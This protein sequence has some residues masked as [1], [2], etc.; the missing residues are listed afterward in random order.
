MSARTNILA[1][2]LFNSVN[3]TTAFIVALYRAD[4][5]VFILICYFSHHIATV[6]C[7]AVHVCVEVQ[8]FLCNSSL[9]LS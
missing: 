2:W 4:P 9:L 7:C 6:I 1:V 5:A 3:E 8:L